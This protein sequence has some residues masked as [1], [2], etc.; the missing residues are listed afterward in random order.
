MHTIQKKK[1]R[2]HLIPYFTR[3]LLIEASRL[4]LKWDYNYQIS[5][6]IAEVPDLKY[7]VEDFLVQD[8]RYGQP[9]EQH[10]HCVISLEPFKRDCVFCDVPIEF[11]EKLPK[12][13]TRIPA[14][15]IGER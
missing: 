12:M 6:R 13:R 3:K 4:G 1:R 5:Q 2:T 8:H 14:R 10:I 9:C 11:F 15:F 7:P